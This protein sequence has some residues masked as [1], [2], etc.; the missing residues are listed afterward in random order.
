MPKF[1]MSSII[2]GDKGR[3]KSLVWYK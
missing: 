2:L 1:S 3:N